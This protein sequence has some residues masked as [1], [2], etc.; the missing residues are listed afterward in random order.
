M[1]ENSKNREKHS[2]EVN[3][4]ASRKIYVETNGNTSN[5]NKLWGNFLS[6][7]ESSDEKGSCK[8]LFNPKH[9]KSKFKEVKL[10]MGNGHGFLYKPYDEWVIPLVNWANNKV[11]RKII[12]S[13]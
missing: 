12:Q 11:A 1:S 4:P 6:I 5:K 13:H 2:S 8:S 3:L 7:Y 10:N 9:R